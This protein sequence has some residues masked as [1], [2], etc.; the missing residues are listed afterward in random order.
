MLSNS[1]EHSRIMYRKLKNTAYCIDMSAKCHRMS[2][3]KSMEY[4]MNST[5][6]CPKKFYRIFQKHY[7]DCFRKDLVTVNVNKPGYCSRL[8]CK[9]CFARHIIPC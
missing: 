6:L 2:Y 8:L 3:N 7:A 5:Q 4:F 1:T 9:L